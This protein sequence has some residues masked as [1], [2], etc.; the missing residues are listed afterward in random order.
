MIN[1]KFKVGDKVRFRPDIKPNKNYWNDVDMGHFWTAPSSE[2]LAQ[3]LSED[4]IV[5]VIIDGHRSDSDFWYQVSSPNIIWHYR[6]VEQVLISAKSTM[7]CFSE[8]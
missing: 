4:W 1:P 3:I 2:K 5:D 7:L 8:I 6:P